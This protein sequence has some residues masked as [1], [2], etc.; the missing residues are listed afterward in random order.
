M[1]SPAA[2]QRDLVRAEADRLE[3]ASGGSRLRRART[4]HESGAREALVLRAVARAKQG[5][6]EAVRFLYLQYADNVYG[7]VCSLVQDPHE[8]QDVTQGLFMRLPRAL[9]SYEP[10]LVPFSAWILRVARNAAI[11]HVRARRPVPSED[12]RR[13]IEEDDDP[14][15][16][17]RDLHDALGTLPEDQRK[18][19][20]L[21]F[22]LGLSPAEV[23]E[24]LGRSVE[25]VHALQHRGRR[26]LKAELLRNQAGPAALAA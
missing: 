1:R 14:R 25:A 21:R 26:T 13:P 23:A 6:D 19:I 15:A 24:R 3:V 18:V 12:V 7:Y 5:D 9:R 2:V 22:I 8:A 4:L 11:D 17:S 16:R 10:R 20:V